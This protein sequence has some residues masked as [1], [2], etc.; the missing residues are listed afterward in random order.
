[1]SPIV[2]LLAFNP[3]LKLAADVNQGHGYS[4]ELL[5]QNSDDFPPLDSTIYVKWV[6]QSDKPSGWN[7]AR[8]SENL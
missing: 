1:M 4:I 2:F 5:L 6:K 8:V 3:L 7:R